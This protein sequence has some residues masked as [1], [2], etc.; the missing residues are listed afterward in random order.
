M[1]HRQDRL[2]QV[3]AIG[4]R[5]NIGPVLLAQDVQQRR[6]D[7][8]EI[9]ADALLRALG[10]QLGVR[11]L[12]L[13]EHARQLRRLQ[14]HVGRSQRDHRLDVGGGDVLLRLRHRNHCVKPIQQRLVELKRRRVRL[15]VRRRHHGAVCQRQPEAGALLEDLQ[16]QVLALLAGAGDLVDD[17]GRLVPDRALVGYEVQPPRLQ[18]LGIRDAG[19]VDQVV[20]GGVVKDEAPCRRN[21]WTGR[22]PG[23]SCRCRDGR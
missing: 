22:A 1:P 13:G 15:G 19:D 4:A 18:R 9:L 11:L 8:A 6:H 5:R 20:L 16:P 7:F 14:R 3:A 17:D 10:E 12:D 2:R 23:A 21:P